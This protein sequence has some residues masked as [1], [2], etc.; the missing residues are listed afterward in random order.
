MQGSCHQRPPAVYAPRGDSRTWP[1]ALYLL[2]VPVIA[3]RSSA[4]AAQPAR[5]SRRRARSTARRPT[6]PPASIAN[7]QAIASVGLGLGDKG[8]LVGI[9]VAGTESTLHNVD[10]GDNLG[11]G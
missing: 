1:G 10:H 11:I 3:T 6:W 8:V 4:A 7:A 9:V 2:A 5:C